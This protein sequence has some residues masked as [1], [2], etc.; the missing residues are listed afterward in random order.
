[1]HSHIALHH[2]NIPVVVVLELILHVCLLRFKLTHFISSDQVSWVYKHNDPILDPFVHL[3]SPFSVGLMW[4]GEASRFK[5][6]ALV[7]Q[8]KPLTLPSV[9]RNLRRWQVNT[10]PWGQNPTAPVSAWSEQP[11][12]VPASLKGNEPLI[13]PQPLLCQPIR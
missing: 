9:T 4:T 13:I 1:M 6:L 12:K 10:V 8:H 7:L 2:W 5:G 3:F 11:I